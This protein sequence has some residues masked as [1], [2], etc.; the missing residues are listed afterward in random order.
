MSFKHLLLRIKEPRTASCRLSQPCRQIHSKWPV[1][2]IHWLNNPFENLLW[3]SDTLSRLFFFFVLFF[4]QIPLYRR[5]SVK[6]TSIK[7]NKKKMEMNALTHFKSL[8]AASG[9]L[10]TQTL[11]SFQMSLSNPRPELGESHMDGSPSSC[12]PSFNPLLF[13][14]LSMDPS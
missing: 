3:D 1:I 2:F 12:F 8:R 11:A 9:S 14:C 7:K 13:L 5:F 10:I 6:E 4:E